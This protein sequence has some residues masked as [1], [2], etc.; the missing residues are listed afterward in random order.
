M[1]VYPFGIDLFSR[2]LQHLSGLFAGYRRRIGSPW[3][4]LTWGQQ[5][6]LI[7]AHLRC[8]AT[9]ARLAAAF[10]V[11]I[12]TVH[13]YIREIVDLAAALAPTRP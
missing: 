7:L 5:A 4:R 1:L 11:G 12:T 8:G 3:R 2:T 10:R 6:L 9:Y 13:R